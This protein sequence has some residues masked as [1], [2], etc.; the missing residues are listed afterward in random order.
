MAANQPYA[1]LWKKGLKIGMP[2]MLLGSC[3]IAKGK[4]PRNL[5]TPSSGVSTNS[6]TAVFS[7][8]LCEKV[9]NVRLDENDVGQGIPVVIRESCIAMRIRWPGSSYTLDTDKEKGT[10][11]IRYALRGNQWIGPILPRTLNR[12]S[13]I[14]WQP[15][16]IMGLM[17]YNGTVTLRLKRKS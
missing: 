10:T 1:D 5:P 11:L 2:L 14:Y 8:P 16:D 12:P 7:P 9:L 15:E 17:G 6:S 4:A 13:D 3:M